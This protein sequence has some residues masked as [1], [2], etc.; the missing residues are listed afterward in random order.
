MNRFIL[1]SPAAALAFLLAVWFPAAV[2]GQSL[3]HDD[4]SKSMY[5]D[6]RASQV[7]D[8]ITILVQE[9]TTASKNN[10]TKTERNSSLSQAITSFLYSPGASGLLTKHG[11]LPALAYT[12]DAKHDGSGSINNAEN[13]IARIAVRIVDVLP[14]RNFIVEGKRETS[15]SGEHQT[16]ILRGVVRADDVAANNTIYSYNIADA[17]IRFVGKGTITDSQRKGWFNKIWDK[18]SPF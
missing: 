15:F 18:V 5:A 4:T 12:S 17:S 1:F 16:I 10:E 6:K 2:R 13:I 14:N 9:N 11:Q 8:I 7:G 3:W